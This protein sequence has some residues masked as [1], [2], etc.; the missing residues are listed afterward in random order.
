[1][2]PFFIW[3]RLDNPAVLRLII[4][5]EATDPRPAYRHTRVLAVGVGYFGVCFYLGETRTKKGR[6]R[7]GT[8][9]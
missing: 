9:D 5:S 8:D 4:R 1:M 3:A 7:R 6:R 2:N